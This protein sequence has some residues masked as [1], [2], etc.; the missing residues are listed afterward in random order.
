MVTRS[1]N[2]DVFRVTEPYSRDVDIRKMGSDR[3]LSIM[4]K[5]QCE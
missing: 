4:I 2:R 1:G 5:I 3:S